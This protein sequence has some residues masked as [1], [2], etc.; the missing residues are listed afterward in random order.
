LS[1]NPNLTV[2]FNTSDEF[3]PVTSTAMPKVTPSLYNH[4]AR[5]TTVR[6]LNVATSA[7]GRSS[8]SFASSEVSVAPVAPAPDAKDDYYAAAGMDIDD[9]DDMA[10]EPVTTED[11]ETVEVLPGVQVHF[12]QP[13]AKRYKN[14]VSHL[15]N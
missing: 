7:S 15:D 1:F 8:Y 6:Q 9:F 12:H 14:S 3:F 2:S 4:K 5:D 10:N 11:D 13:K